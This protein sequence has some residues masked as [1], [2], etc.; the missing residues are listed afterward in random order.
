MNI[1][2]DD[3]NNNNIIITLFI[4]IDRRYLDTS[5]LL[6]IMFGPMNQGKCRKTYNI[7]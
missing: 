2:N 6:F 7:Q 5:T 4:F 1:N 3:N